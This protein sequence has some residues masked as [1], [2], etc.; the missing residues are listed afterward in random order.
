MEVIFQTWLMRQY[1]TGS[2]QHCQLGTRGAEKL[3]C[4]VS[5]C[6]T[7]KWSSTF[8]DKGFCHL[9]Y[10]E[11]QGLF[12]GSETDLNTNFRSKDHL[13]CEDFYFIIC[14]LEGHF[15]IRKSLL[16]LWVRGRDSKTR[17]TVR[18]M[19]V[20]CCP[21]LTQNQ[22]QTQGTAEANTWFQINCRSKI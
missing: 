15:L 22:T 12:N 9:D 4:L 19:R 13:I 10:Y 3:N 21:H 8:D 5:T 11:F 17:L 6:F 16:Q 1:S 20:W 14:F 7:R 18:F 2:F